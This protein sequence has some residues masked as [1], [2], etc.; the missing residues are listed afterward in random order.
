MQI[1]ELY[2]TKDFMKPGAFD[3]LDQI[4]AGDIN[5]R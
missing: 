5:R 2:V 1:K 4:T 3:H